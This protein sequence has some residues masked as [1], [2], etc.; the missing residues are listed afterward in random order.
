MTSDQISQFEKKMIIRN[1]EDAD[2]E[3]IIALQLVCFPNMHPWKKSQME[4]HIRIFPLNL[5]HASV[6]FEQWTLSIS[7]ALHLA[8]RHTPHPTCHTPQTK[9]HINH[10]T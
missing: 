3:Q 10:S 9:V 4:S 2:I 1:I 6:S 7:L 5:P 8:A